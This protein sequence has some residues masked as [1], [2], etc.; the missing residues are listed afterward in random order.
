MEQPTCGRQILSLT[1]LSKNFVYTLRQL[2]RRDYNNNNKTA[3]ERDG[4]TEA[5]ER[6][7]ERERY[8]QTDR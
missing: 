3:R 8:R 5:R 2:H 6:E 1:Q 7:R 4:Q